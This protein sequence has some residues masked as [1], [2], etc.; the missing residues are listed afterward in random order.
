MVYNDLNSKLC[1]I[2][3]AFHIHSA[4]DAPLSHAFANDGDT[5]EEQTERGVE[6]LVVPDLSHYSDVSRHHQML[7]ELFI[8]PSGGDRVTMTLLL[9]PRVSVFTHSPVLS[10]PT[11]RSAHCWNGRANKIHSR[12]KH[13]DT[14]H[15]YTAT[16]ERILIKHDYNVCL[17]TGLK[18]SQMWSE[19]NLRWA[20]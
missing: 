10:T 7:S 15:T 1:D 13:G 6:A 20:R 9:Y 5:D 8:S 3:S 2:R 12:S 4:E 19:P 17:K 11:P 16:P 14:L 18:I